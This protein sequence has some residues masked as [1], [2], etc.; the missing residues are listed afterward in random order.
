MMNGMYWDDYGSGSKLQVWHVL[1]GCWLGS[2]D[3]IGCICSYCCW[4][5]PY[6]ILDCYYYITNTKNGHSKH[7]FVDYLKTN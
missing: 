2:E 6:I 1:G 3:G 5:C 7:T 4:Q